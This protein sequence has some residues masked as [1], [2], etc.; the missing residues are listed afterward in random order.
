MSIP[1]DGQS[2]DA[3]VPG[4]SGTNTAASGVGVR[5]QNTTPGTG[6]IGV[7]G[8]SDAVGVWGEGKTWHGVA[9]V[10]HSTTGGAGVFGSSDVGSGII[11]ASQVWHAILA[12][13][14]VRLAVQACGLR[15]RQV[16]LQVVQVLWELARPGMGCMARARAL[17]GGQ[18]S[19]VN[20]LAMEQAWL[21]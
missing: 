11:A 12:P 20:I 6:G 2:T 7:R 10:S 14:R 21:V 16:V 15:I 18:G 9:G 1:Y 17:L 3:G 4:I 8:D 19:L 13:A 5:G